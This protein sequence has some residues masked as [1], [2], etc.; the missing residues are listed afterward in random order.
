MKS[1]LILWALLFHTGVISVC[2]K[3]TFLSVALLCSVIYHSCCVLI[4]S[5]YASSLAI[6]PQK[7]IPHFHLLHESQRNKIRFNVGFQSFVSECGQTLIIHIFSINHATVN[8]L[9][10]SLAKF[11]RSLPPWVY[12]CFYFGAKTQFTWCCWTVKWRRLVKAHRYISSRY[13]LRLESGNSWG[14]KNEWHTNV[15]ATRWD[16]GK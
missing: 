10:I 15:T 4:F 9:R 14:L 7:V 5:N 12:L 2:L 16:F 8:Y 3:F 6:F 11:V 1:E 13:D